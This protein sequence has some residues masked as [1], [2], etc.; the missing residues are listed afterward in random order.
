MA[1]TCLFLALLLPPV[2]QADYISLSAFSA[3][4]FIYPSASI[5][6]SG[7]DAD[8]NL[9]TFNGDISIGALVPS[10]FD[11]SGSC[12]AIGPHCIY[13][14]YDLDGTFSATATIDDTG[15]LLGGSYKYILGSPTLGIASGTE[16][17]SGTLTSIEWVNDGA[18]LQHVGTVDVLD[19]R[20][21]AFVGPVN[22]IL[23]DH[24]VSR[25]G[26]WAGAPWSTTTQFGQWSG[27]PY[28]YLAQAV[29]EPEV[30]ALMLTGFG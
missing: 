2:S 27:T 20:F 7:Y 4:F 13:L 22:S 30:W 3:T 5:I 28:V 23:I 6:P 25:P 29:P 10:P 1:R 11:F 26:P 24:S 9:Y 17:L 8:T 16:V 15:T 18:M 21:A 12:T 19:S 14:A